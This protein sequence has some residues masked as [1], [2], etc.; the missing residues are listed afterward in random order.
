MRA[1]AM[2]A[3]SADGPP[4]SASVASGLLALTKLDQ[5][6]LAVTLL[7]DLWSE[8]KDGVSTE[9][10]ILVIDEALRSQQPEA[11][12]VAAELLCRNATR[13]SPCQSLHW[14]SVVD[15]CWDP[16]FGPKTKFLLL[17]ALLRMTL[18]GGEQEDALR[19]IAVRLYGVWRGD[20]DERIKGCVGTLIAA[21]VPA[22]ASLG[23]TDFLQGNSKVLLSDLREAAASAT[24]NPDRF[25]D[26]IVAARARELR[27]WAGRC[28]GLG[29]GGGSLATAA[30]L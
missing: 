2:F 26:R 6:G 22:L 9:T 11:Q 28:D 18:H 30:Q 23:Y 17:D 3:H 8:G 7:V 25:L 21:L 14:P 5:A 10:A 20:P 13:L 27:A 4:S 12:L 15:G 19:A 1:G 16:A 24:Q 29:S